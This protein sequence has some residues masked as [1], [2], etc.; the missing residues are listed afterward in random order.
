MQT[1]WSDFN[2][3]AQWSMWTFFAHRHDI[4]PGLGGIMFDDIGPN[5]RQGTAIFNDSF[6]STAPAGDPNPNAW[7]RRMQFWTG[8]HEMGHA[9]NL[10]HSWQKA[11]GTPWIALQNDPE[12]RSFMNYPF[13]VNGGQSQFFS[14]FDFRFTD[15]EL[16]FMRHAPARFVQMGN[17]DWFDHHG[18]EQAEQLP[19]AAGTLE[20]RSHRDGAYII[21][22][23]WHSVASR[24]FVCR[25]HVRSADCIE[26]AADTALT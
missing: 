20:A 24:P 21:A 4:G 13:N 8:V 16:L 26:G 3:V 18:F 22:L 5:H 12:A 10:A 7:V 15:P 23:D 1:F 14:D 17:A 11:L 25:A 6:I 19:D 9:F 2:N